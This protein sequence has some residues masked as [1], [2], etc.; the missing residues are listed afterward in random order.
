MTPHYIVL[1]ITVLQRSIYCYD[2]EITTLER[3]LAGSYTAAYMDACVARICHEVLL[4]NPLEFSRHDEKI[5]DFSTTP[6]GVSLLNM[7]TEF[8]WD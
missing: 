2:S 7:F 4:I 5:I 6:P 8:S 3:L 1:L